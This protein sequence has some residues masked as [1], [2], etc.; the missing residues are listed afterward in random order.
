MHRREFAAELLA[1][2]AGSALTVQSLGATRAGEP[3][4]VD[5]RRFG[6]LG[7]GN[8]DD[9]EAMS[10]AI[11][12]GRPL[13]IGGLTIRITTKLR[14]HNDRQL[15]VA[16]GGSFKFDGP[17]NDRLLDITASGVCFLGVKF[18][19]NGKQVN[20]C[21]LYVA[22]NAADPKFVRCGFTNIKGTHSGG[23]VSDHSN[24]QY[25]VMISP[26]GVEGFNF[27]SCEFTEIYNDNSGLSGV[28]PSVGYGFAGGVFFLTDDFA[29]PVARQTVVTSGQFRSCVFR[30]IRTLLSPGLSYAN[31][32]DYQDAD[33]IRF[34]GD[35]QG[36]TTLNV[37]VRDCHFQDCAK[38]AVK[39]ALAKGVTVS[40]VTVIATE[41]LPYPMVT[42]VKVDGDNCQVHGLRV[43]SPANAPIRMIIQ[44]HDCKDIRINDVFA[45][46]CNLFWSIAP[47][48]R[49]V[50]TSGWRV[51][52]LRCASIVAPAGAPCGGGI[53][54]ETL[55]ERFEDCTFENVDFQCDGSSHSMLAGFFAAATRCVGVDLRG[56][57][58]RNGD[59]KISGF[60][61]LL[62]DMNQEIE[63]DRYVSSAPGRGPLEAGQ[64][65]GVLA[66]RDSRIEGYTLNVRAIPKGYLNSRLRYLALICGD[67][68]HVS[69]LHLSVPDSLTK[70]TNVE[71]FISNSC[72]G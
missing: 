71:K 25:A 56:W 66:T 45:D 10:R 38:R 27:D 20:A 22:S 35:L 42:A 28:T 57:R 21:L 12:S 26:Y 64:P 24:A 68:T 17:A 19:G 7:D 1:A 39:V 15:I 41:A 51:T 62:E 69:G 58:I 47:R 50:V 65:V 11:K 60:G 37:T 30:N 52:D 14:F 53:C 63:D 46:R 8:A 40:G 34:Y 67:H 43:F 5:V 9:T 48:S 13:D 23:V 31:S 54:V 49:S 44:T 72:R 18:D 32:I 16:R 36:A 29:S 4:S 33:G 61:Y 2:I 59:L 55:P 3:A 6:V 70:Q